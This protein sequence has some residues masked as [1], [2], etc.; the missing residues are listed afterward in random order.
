MSL[1]IIL[2][3]DGTLSDASHRSHFVDGDVKDWASFLQPHLVLQDTVIKGARRGHDHLV[4]I[5]KRVIFLTGRNESLR[6]VTT[7]WLQTHFGVNVVNEGLVM[8]PIGDNRVPTAFKHEM[9]KEIE[10]WSPS[11]YTIAI[12]DDKFMMKIYR[13]LGYVVLHAPKCWKTMFPDFDHLTNETT[14]RR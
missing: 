13:D 2:D 7:E 1:N 4:K 14:W 8:R 10:I 6:P 3:I 5:A 11:D 12:D 9:L